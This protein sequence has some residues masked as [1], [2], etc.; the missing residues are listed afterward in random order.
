M[1]A[2]GMICQY[3]VQ[4]FP[5]CLGDFDDFIL[6]ETQSAHPLLVPLQARRPPPVL[7]RECVPCSLSPH[8]PG[9][10][11]RVGESLQGLLAPGPFVAAH[12]LAGTCQQCLQSPSG[13]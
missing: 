9:G 1:V 13:G 4:F 6:V 11:V 8:P 5:D 7:T 2:P 12:S 10:S 3:I